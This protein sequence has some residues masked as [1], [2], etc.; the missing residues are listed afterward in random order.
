M[1]SPRTDLQSPPQDRPPC[2]PQDRPPGPLRAAISQTPPAASRRTLPTRSRPAPAPLAPASPPSS[3]R[4]EG[5]RLEQGTL[6]EFTAS[7]SCVSRSAM[8]PRTQKR[9]SCPLG[10]DWAIYGGSGPITELPFW[11]V[12][13]EARC[14][15]GAGL[16][17]DP[18]VG[19][20]REGGSAS[21]LR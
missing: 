19:G 13:K 20:A 16:S 12:A 4:G 9:Q 17:A 8:L 10:R 11:G 2:P 6:T 14:R 5:G 7:C 15:G 3:G 21:W 18:D 1:S